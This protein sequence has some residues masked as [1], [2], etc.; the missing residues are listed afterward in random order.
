V[1]RDFDFGLFTGMGSSEVRGITFMTP[2][3]IRLDGEEG[4][5]SD[6]V[7]E[8]NRFV[9]PPG[10][11]GEGVLI[12]IGD[13][14]LVKDNSIV[15]WYA[16]VGIFSTCRNCVGP[17]SRFNRIEHNR[18]FGNGYG[19]YIAG[20]TADGNVLQSNDVVHNRFD[21]IYLGSGS[22]NT[23]V[24]R[25][26]TDRNGTDG[27]ETQSEF[28]TLTGNHTWLN[29][30]L[31]IEAVPRTQGGGNWAKHNGNPAQCVPASLCST[32]G[33]PKQ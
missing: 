21:G 20:G 19:V 22:T 23:L 2:E 28:A 31:G 27:I 18:L 32:T 25:N 26:S 29:G 11:G 13:R 14:N 30:N 3:G 4:V 10:G 1:L 8:D 16:G 7:I 12:R 17:K 15:G 6:N 5:A 24:E 33:K 9:A